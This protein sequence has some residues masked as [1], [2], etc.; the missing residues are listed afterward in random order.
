VKKIV[1]LA[2]FCFCGSAVFSFELAGHNWAP[3]QA[4]ISVNI[5]GLSDSGASWNTAFQVAMSQWTAATAF[6]FHVDNSYVDPCMMRAAGEFGDGIPSVDFR[7][8]ICGNAFGEGIIAINLASGLC[9]IDD[10]STGFNANDAD[11][12]FN[13]NIDWDIYSGDINPDTPDFYRV[14]L[15][16]LGHALGL[17][18]E[19]EVPSIM[20]TNVSNIESLQLDDILGATALYGGGS[21]VK[22]IYGPTVEIPQGSELEGDFNVVDLSGTLDADDDV[23]NGRPIDIYQFTVKNDSQVEIALTLGD[24][25]VVLRIARVTSMQ[26]IVGGYDFTARR[27]GRWK[28]AGIISELQAGTYWVATTPASA[29]SQGSLDYAINLTA[30]VTSFESSFSSVTAPF[31]ASVQVNP[32]PIITGNLDSSDYLAGGRFSDY[33]QFKVRRPTEVQIDLTSAEFDPRLILV[34]VKGNRTLDL[35]S[36]FQ[37]SNS[38]QSVNARVRQ[39][40]QRGTYW[41]G[42]TSDNIEESGSYRIDISLI[43]P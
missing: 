2:A 10:C 20:N 17:A 8:D 24:P 40:L 27:I 43:L 7:S 36:F 12:L 26:D 3:R 35:R 15:H 32:N 14:A 11:T 4:T 19:D 18:H 1:I 41:I 16:E 29:R 23:L 28:T 31:G 25:D 22:T 34:K 42:A 5:D 37:D 39:T 6:D 9:L 33:Y 21:S 30:T 13:D 38:G